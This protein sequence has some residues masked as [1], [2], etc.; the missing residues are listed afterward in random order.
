MRI[1]NSQNQL[2]LNSAILLFDTSEKV[3]PRTE[4]M[5][6]GLPLNS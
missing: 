4:S 3:A 6:T 2:L 5:T 1:K